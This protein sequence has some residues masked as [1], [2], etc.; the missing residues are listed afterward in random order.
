MFMGS[1]L[2][3]VAPDGVMILPSFIRE[4]LAL[5]SDRAAILLGG[6]DVDACLTGYDP[7]QVAALQEE[8]RRR[9]LADDASKPG[10][11]H[12]RERR[13]FSLLHN[14]P[15]DAKGC[16]RLP[17]LL[18]RRARIRDAA[19]LVGTGDAFELWGLN[20]ALYGHDAGM[21]TLASLSIELSQAA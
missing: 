15:V 16:I 8:C 13:L 6:H 5:R 1:A 7:A 11:S 12:A 10:A 20:V 3:E 18:R 2:C 4:P 21:R 14:V 9:R 19:L 17:E